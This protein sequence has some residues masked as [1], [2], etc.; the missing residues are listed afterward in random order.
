[1]LFSSFLIAVIGVILVAAFGQSALG[2]VFILP[3]LCIYSTT[4]ALLGSLA[5]S[6]LL[7]GL[8]THSRAESAG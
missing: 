1:M 7:Y 2:I 4:P 6:C 3:G 5:T 8:R